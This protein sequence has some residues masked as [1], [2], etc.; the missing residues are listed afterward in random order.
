MN[1]VRLAILSVFVFRLA[2]SFIRQN[3]EK[4]MKI[5]LPI[6]LVSVFVLGCERGSD[7]HAR[8]TPTSAPSTATATVEPASSSIAE[9]KIA[10]DGAGIPVPPPGH[11]LHTLAPAMGLMLP[12]DWTVER[13]EFRE[14]DRT[15]PLFVRIGNATV[16]FLAAPESDTFPQPPDLISRGIDNWILKEGTTV[17]VAGKE[18]VYDR[19]TGP[20]GVGIRGRLLA[21]GRL[22]QQAKRVWFW[23]VGPES[24]I[25]KV[26]AAART[27]LV[28][29]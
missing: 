25:L 14:S 5:I 21:R 18:F 28:V 12:E 3:K 15:T 8:T 17:D 19:A 4:L 24:D 11:K 20:K 2:F 10:R 23:G 1:L 13:G 16:V 26:V 9:G 29:D 6:V 27:G 22:E 7:D